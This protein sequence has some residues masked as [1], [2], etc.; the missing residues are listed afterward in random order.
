MA[1]NSAQ[2]Q[3]WN[4]QQ[5]S[6]LGQSQSQA[7]FGQSNQQGLYGGVSPWASGASTPAGSN[8]QNQGG[9]SPIGQQYDYGAPASGGGGGL[10]GQNQ[11]D[12]TGTSAGTTGAPQYDYSVQGAYGTGDATFGATPMAGVGPANEAIVQGGRRE[13][14]ASWDEHRQ[15][16]AYTM[17]DAVQGGGADPYDTEAVMDI[18]RELQERQRKEG[19]DQILNQLAGAGL[20]TSGVVG[21]T[22]A[23]FEGSLADSLL[24]GNLNAINTGAGYARQDENLRQQQLSTYGNLVGNYYGQDQYADESQKDREWS[25]YMTGKYGT[26]DQDVV[27][28]FDPNSLA[29]YDLPGGEPTPDITPWTEPTQG[30]TSPASPYTAPSKWKDPAPRPTPDQP[31]GSEVAPGATGESTGGGRDWEETRPDPWEREQEQGKLDARD[32]YL[33]TLK[34]GTPEEQEAARQAMKDAGYQDWEITE[35]TKQGSGG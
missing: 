32:A 10:P 21:S 8:A 1:W 9:W 4:K 31:S 34:G 27:G 23:D 30:P 7:G 3:Q 28:G 14:T 35:F 15:Q 29:L 24:R 33:E 19:H 22:M 5:P 20:N 25:D 13:P 11:W 17:W 2:N 18:L 16:A 12:K 6:Q 26:V